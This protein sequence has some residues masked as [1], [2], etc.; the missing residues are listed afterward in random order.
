MAISFFVT[1]VSLI[2]PWPWGMK[3]QLESQV[4]HLWNYVFGQVNNLTT[5]LLPMSGKMGRVGKEVIKT[6]MLSTCVLS[7]RQIPDRF[8]KWVVR[9]LEIPFTSDS[10]EQLWPFA[11]SVWLWKM[12]M[13]PSG[14]S[15]TVQPCCLLNKEGLGQVQGWTKALVSV[16]NTSAGCLY[17]QRYDVP[18][19]RRYLSL[20]V[21]CLD[22][23]SLLKMLTAERSIGFQRAH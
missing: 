7:G 23:S 17:A 16:V 20:N 13:V 5:L 9:C 12:Q 4:L 2:L 6:C 10:M 15:L 22:I 3:S 14:V 1:A 19:S 11:V 8:L 18:Q 21:L